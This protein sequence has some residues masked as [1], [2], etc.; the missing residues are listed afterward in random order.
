MTA[1]DTVTTWADGIRQTALK[2]V[3]KHL[4]SRINF[5]RRHTIEF[6]EDSEVAIHTLLQEL[7][8]LAAIIQ[9]EQ[10]KDGSS[11]DSN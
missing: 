1:L 6:T 5:W 9:Q 11:P 10:N 2:D 7:E 3:A 8:D 4:D